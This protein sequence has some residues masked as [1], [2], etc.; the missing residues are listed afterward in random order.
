[1]G[2]GRRLGGRD[3]HDVAGRELVAVG[4]VLVGGRGAA[5]L[6]VGDGVGR[7]GE[8]GAVVDLA[9]GRGGDRQLGLV[10]RHDQLA[11]RSSNAVVVS[12]VNCFL[13]LT[14]SNR[15][16]CVLEATIGIGAN[17]PAGGRSVTR[18]GQDLT[19]GKA[20]DL[21]LISFDGRARTSNCCGCF[22]A[23]LHLT[24]VGDILVLDGNRQRGLSHLKRAE[25][26]GDGV[27]V[28]VN[29]APIDGVRVVGA[30][31]H[32]LRAS[33]FDGNGRISHHQTS[34]GGGVVGQ[35]RAVVSPLSTTGGNRQL[36]RQDLQ[37]AGTHIQAHAVVAIAGRH[38]SRGERQVIRNVTNVL[39]GLNVVAEASS[40]LFDVAKARNH[41]PDGLLVQIRISLVA[42]HDVVGTISSH[43]GRVS[44]ANQIVLAGVRSTGPTVG[45]DADGDVNLGH[46][47]RAADVANLVVVR[48]GTLAGNGRI[49]RGHR[50]G[51]GV[52]AAVVGRVVRVGIAERNGRQSVAADQSVNGHLA[53]KLGGQR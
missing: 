51:A 12:Y 25:V 48:V 23:A 16:C 30:A 5:L 14:G 38:V 22:V 31:N 17:T 26:L 13:A 49:L 32:S 10:G 11:G 9:V 52:D 21:V 43:L 46:L 27:V 45:L 19:L 15:D 28:L 37:A 39:L 47:E 50:R 6:A 18:D 33:G 40:A 1:M 35:R 42:D 24:V 7:G 53:R 8:R 41:I 4:A 34:K 29:V 44:E 2:H 20:L 36:G 3:G